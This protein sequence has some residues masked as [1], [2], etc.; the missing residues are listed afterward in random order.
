MIP[1]ANKAPWNETAWPV[2][3]TCDGTGLVD[4]IDFV[5]VRLPNRMGFSA[6]GRSEPCPDCKEEKR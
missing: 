6:V 2:C 3:E 4:V 1:L 5:P